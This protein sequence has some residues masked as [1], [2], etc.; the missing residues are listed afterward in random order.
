MMTRPAFAPQ[1]CAA[2]A[3]ACAVPAFAQADRGA[4]GAP[5]AADD[6]FTQRGA[7]V[8]G[9]VIVNVALDGKLLSVL[10]EAPAINV[11]G[12]ERA[13]RGAAEQR[14]V[15]IVDRWLA[16]GA[17]ILD[18]PAGAGCKLAQA[19]YTPPQLGGNARQDHDHDHDH[20]HEHDSAAGDDHADYD[21]RYT[22]ECS[23]PAALAWVELALVKRLRNLAEVEVNLATARGQTQQTLGAEGGRIALR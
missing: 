8:H 16:S 9:K 4:A 22:Y 20:E 21:A 3:L 2:L 17:G 18:V 13:P 12:F 1:L 19:E 23:N 14:T 7:H 5:G 10:L 6:G 15:A 11:L